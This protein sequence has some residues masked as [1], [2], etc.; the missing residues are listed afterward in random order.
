M[1]NFAYEAPPTCATFMKSEMFGRLIAGPVGSGKTTAC[2]VELLRRAINQA[3]AA[4]GYRYTRF[5]IVRQTLKQLKDTVGKDVQSWLKDLGYWKVSEN[6]YYLEFDDVRSEWPFIPLEDAADQARLLSMQLTG[7]WLSEA[8]EMDL[9]VLGPISGRLGR[10]PSGARGTP[11]W[12]GWI[13]DTN[14]PTEMTPWHQFMENS[15]VGVSIFKQPSGLSPAAENLNWLVQND[16]T[17]KLPIDDPARLAQGRR[18]YERFVEQYGE[19]S[20]WVRRYVYAEYGD[21]PSGAAVFKASFRSDFHIVEDTQLIPG[22]PLLI[23]QDFGRNP[24]SLICQMDHLGRLLVHEEV[25]GVNTGLEK[26][27]LQNLKP[28][29]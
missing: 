13:A 15:P 9:D 12:H 28:R 20:D 18:Y 4:D 19:N 25:P 2:L 1:A 24:W 29:L 3:P 14:F 10:Y 26:H 21:D 5:A 22:Y 17:I 11:T 16:K 27:I 23:G 7:C 8:V 6:T